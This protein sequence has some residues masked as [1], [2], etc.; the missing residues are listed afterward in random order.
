MNK[1]TKFA[2]IYNVNPLPDN[3]WEI[4]RDGKAKPHRIYSL[5]NKYAEDLTYIIVNRNCQ[6]NIYD[7]HGNIERKIISITPNTPNMVK[8]VKP[9]KNK[10][11]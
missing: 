7:E 1:K 5:F 11:R 4:R 9:D 8:A 6:I 2:L 10:E 3:K